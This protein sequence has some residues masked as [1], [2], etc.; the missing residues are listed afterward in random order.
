MTVVV[1]PHATL[2]LRDLGRAP[3]ERR[4]AALAAGHDLRPTYNGRGALYQVFRSLRDK[5]RKTVL[6]PAFQCPTVVDPLLHAACDVEYYEIDEQLRIDRPTLLARL[7]DDVLAVILINYFGIEE[8]L[9]DLIAECR[10]R[11][12]LVVEDCSH[13]F[14]RTDPLEL[15]G[16]RGDLA[17]FSFWKLLPS[18][19]GGAIRVNPTHRALDGRP[20]PVPW[21]ASVQLARQL[22]GEAAD[23][24]LP[25]R[26][27]R[28]QQ[29]KGTVQGPVE[30]AAAAVAYPYDRQLAAA[31]MP[32]LARA[33]LEAS[34]LGRACEARR[35]HFLLLD[36]ML[37]RS[38]HATPLVTNLPAR[39]CPWGYPLL[40][41]NRRDNDY[42]LRA[43]GVPLFTFGEVLHPT[44]DDPRR[45]SR[46]ATE[47]AHLLA[48]R[49]LVLGIHQD[50]DERT[51]QEACGVLNA[52]D[53]AD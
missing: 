53:W 9:D 46:R 11:G 24:L 41:K 25:A 2:R 36:R 48:D 10:R 27:R 40:L 47:I 12:I 39:C 3:R 30:R 42:R 32:A 34:D 44:V 52:F 6:V 7:A 23:D 49:L 22:L 29:S 33:I 45:A 14:L 13:S 4:F 28:A 26:R 43:R 15:A 1:S 38:A 20:G 50:L 31:Q 35:K 21:A 37:S 19:V 17:M 18:R 8:P 16:A 5:Q 51:L